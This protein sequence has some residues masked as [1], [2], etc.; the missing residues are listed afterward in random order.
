M[1]VKYAIVANNLVDKFS[2]L[3]DNGLGPEL[4]LIIKENSYDIIVNSIK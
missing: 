4:V 1:K 3:T 2:T